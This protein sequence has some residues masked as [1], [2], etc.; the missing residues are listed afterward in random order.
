[1]LFRSVNL[2]FR[3]SFIPEQH[4]RDGTI[5][6]RWCA[7]TQTGEIALECKD[8]FDSFT[9]CLNDARTQGYGG[10]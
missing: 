9:D 4:K 1:M 6:W 10:R 7:Y 5:R 2:P 8:S 3:W